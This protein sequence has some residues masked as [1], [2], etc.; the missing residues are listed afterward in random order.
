MVIFAFPLFLLVNTGI[1]IVIIIADRHRLRR[2]PEL[3]GRRPGRLVPRTVQRQHPL[4]RRLHRLPVLRR[5]LRVHPVRRHPALRRLGLGRRRHPLLRLRSHRPDRHPDHQGNLRPRRTRRRR[6]ERRKHARRRLTHPTERQ[7]GAA[8][9]RRPLSA[10][11]RDAGN[12]ANAAAAMPTMKPERYTMA[13]IKR[14]PGPWLQQFEWQLHAACRE[15]Q[16]D[17]RPTS[18][19]ELPTRGPR[20][21]SQG[22]LQRVPRDR[23]LPDSNT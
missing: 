17:P 3:P 12:L 11:P 16:C 19:T 14:L 4:L 22:R 5:R 13:D 23:R 7:A 1:A 2:H 6:T 21:P 18:R 15:V 10:A 9:D 8:D 20:R